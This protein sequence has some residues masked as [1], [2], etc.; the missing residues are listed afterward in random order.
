M[1]LGCITYHDVGTLCRVNGS[2]NFEKDID[3]LDNN[4]WPVVARHF[5]KLFMDDYESVHRSHLSTANGN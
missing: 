1:V 3:I 5:I 2:I 4:L